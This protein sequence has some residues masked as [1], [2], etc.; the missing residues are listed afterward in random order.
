M[1]LLA[2][3]TRHRR[4]TRRAERLACPLRQRLRPGPGWLPSAA[5]PWA[6][7][8][9]GP[10][11]PEAVPVEPAGRLAAEAFRFAAGQLLLPAAGDQTSTRL[12]MRPAAPWPPSAV[13]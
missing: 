1:A 5:G 12:R 3:P 9:S 8:R 11:R 13:P 2:R 10:A 4:R 6:A 7:G